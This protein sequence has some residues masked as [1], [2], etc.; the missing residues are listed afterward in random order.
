MNARTGKAAACFLGVWGLAGVLALILTLTAASEQSAMADSSGPPSPTWDRWQQ[1][2]AADAI[3]FDT[4]T[5]RAPMP[6]GRNFLA[7]AV[8]SDTIYAIGGWQ[9][10]TALTT[11]EAYDPI[12]DS[13]VP[14]AG[15]P[16][17]RNALAAAVVDSK[18]Y[19]VGGWSSSAM[20]VTAA[21]ECYDPTTDN[22][23]SVSPLPTARNGLAAVAL[24]GEIYAIGGWDGSGV[25]NTVTVY[26]PVS[27]IWSI[28][29]P[30]PTARSGL[31]A[32]VVDDRIYAIGGYDGVTVTGKVEI[33]NPATDSWSVGTDMPKARWILGAAVVNDRVYVVGGNDT[34][35]FGA[36]LAINEEYNPN[37]NLWRTVA[38]M[39]T[40]RWGMGIAVFDGRLHAIGGTSPGIGWDTVNEVYLPPAPNQVYLPLIAMNDYARN[41]KPIFVY[42]V[43]GQTLDY[44]G[45]WLFK[46]EPMAYGQGF[47]WS[48]LQN[49]EMVWEN[50]R[51]ERTLSGN[52]YAILEGSVAHNKFIPGSVEVWVRAWENVEWT[53]ARIITIYLE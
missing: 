3:S 7:A 50:W 24:N 27:D 44:A 9:G 39:P 11:T 16:T 4:W 26:N 17:E 42:P 46:V 37:T 33:Y 21:V 34:E 18:V 45:D 20:T 35:D 29:T 6:T 19:A 25:T 8:V 12:G 40:A 41:I 38:P 47:L 51:D 48:F 22:W 30:M 1:L 2:Y 15:M 28:R 43:D 23:K 49:D 13:W 53:E 36:P 52:E 31:A 32:V 5:T 14:R 10:T